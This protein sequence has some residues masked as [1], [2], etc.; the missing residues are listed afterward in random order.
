[1]SNY[2]PLHIR[3]TIKSSPQAVWDAWTKPDQFK[4]W[5]M[6]APFSVASCE[7]DVTPGGKL[8]VDTEDP[9]GAIMPLI[10]EFKVVDE[11]TKLVMTN[12]PLDANGSKLF[13]I[14]HTILITEVDG[15]TILDITSEVLS[16]GPHAEQFLSGMEAG[17]NQAIDQLTV[18]VTK[19]S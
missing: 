18:L 5:Y 8:S 14:L 13:E 2:Q 1:M 11:P 12:S 10:G 16:D 7:F 15:Y 6:P 4:Q 17:L 19:A 3:R 9:N